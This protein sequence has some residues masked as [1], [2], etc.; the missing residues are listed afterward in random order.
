MTG[1]EIASAIPGAL[2]VLTSTLKHCRD[3]TKVIGFWWEIHLEYQ[4]CSNDMKYHHLRYKRN[5][6]QLLLPSVAKDDKIARLIAEPSNDEWKDPDTAQQ[7]EIRRQ[8]SHELYLE[9][10]QQMDGA[11]AKLYNL[12]VQFLEEAQGI[13]GTFMEGYL[14]CLIL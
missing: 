4:K 9:I 10:M 3:V 13:Q 14:R 12:L 11:I 6:K 1:F 2:P 7:L 8:N 5:L